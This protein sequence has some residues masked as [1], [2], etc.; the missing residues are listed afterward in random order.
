MM[1]LVRVDHAD[2][3]CGRCGR[4]DFVAVIANLIPRV[5]LNQIVSDRTSRL[6]SVAGDRLLVASRTL[7]NADPAPTTMCGAI[8]T[9]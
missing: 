8:N 9:A 7:A 3:H 1:S 6:L 5:R 4:V 2:M